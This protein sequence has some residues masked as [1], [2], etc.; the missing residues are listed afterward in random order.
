MRNITELFSEEEGKGQYEAAL[1]RFRLPYWDPV[2]PRNKLK[3]GAEKTLSD[4]VLAMFGLPDILVAEDVWVMRPGDTQKT[5]I[6][7]PLHH[8]EFPQVDDPRDIGRSPINWR[9]SDKF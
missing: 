8:F 6:K 5:T 9:V 1:D 2:M 7:N 4:R 3:P